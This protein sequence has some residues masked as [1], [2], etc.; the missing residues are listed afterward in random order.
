MKKMLKGKPIVILSLLVVIAIASTSVAQVTLV[1]QYNVNV[2]QFTPP[3]HLVSG[4][5]NTSSVNESIN[6]AG[7]VAYVNLTQKFIL[8]SVTTANVTGML[9]IPS[10]ILPDFTYLTNVTSFSG[11]NRVNSIALYSISGN[12]TYYNDYTY[13]S[14][15]GYSNN[16]NPISI[17]KNHNSSLGLYISVGK[18]AYGGPYTWYLTLEIDGYFTSS[19]SASP[20][21]FTQ[22][23]V[24]I[25]VTTIELA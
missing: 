12:G 5:S 20:S 11:Q 9:Y 23:F 19:G 21:V 4:I 16:T 25:Q 3:V 8:G 14:T 17:S 1:N 2:K 24:H 18:S 7:S 10:Q 13:N 22:Y 6:S 15:T